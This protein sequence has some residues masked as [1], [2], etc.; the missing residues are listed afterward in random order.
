VTAKGGANPANAENNPA[1]QSARG[2][3][4]GGKLAFTGLETLWLA[5]FG[6]AMLA[7]GLVLRARTGSSRSESSL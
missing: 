5:L 3:G 7:T 6:G 1:G 2:G 4:A